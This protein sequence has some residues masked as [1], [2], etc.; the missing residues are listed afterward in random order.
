MKIMYADHQFQ[1]IPIVVGALGSEA[2]TG[3]VL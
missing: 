1:M 2:V 3:D